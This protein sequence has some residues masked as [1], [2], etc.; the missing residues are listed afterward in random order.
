M[1]R[2][3][4]TG[5]FMAPIG[6]SFGVVARHLAKEDV[7]GVVAQQGPRHRSGFRRTQFLITCAET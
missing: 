4:V 2:P 7:G 1:V 3:A 5:R 6:P